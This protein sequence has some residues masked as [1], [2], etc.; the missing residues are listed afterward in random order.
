MHAIIKLND[1]IKSSRQHMQVELSQNVEKSEL[2]TTGQ[3][4]KRKKP[5]AEHTNT[6]QQRYINSGYVRLTPR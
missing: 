1:A 6:K 5:K 3:A 4:E 2:L